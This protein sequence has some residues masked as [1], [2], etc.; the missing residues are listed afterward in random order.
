[1]ITLSRKLVLS[2]ADSNST[3]LMAAVLIMPSLKDLFI[4]RACY[5]TMV[6]DQSEVQ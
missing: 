4:I 5:D 6:I 2:A 3:E 1:M